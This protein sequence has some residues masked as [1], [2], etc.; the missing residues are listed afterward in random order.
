MRSIVV[1][2][3]CI[4]SV[5]VL[6]IGLAASLPAKAQRLVGS[7][8]AGA[9]GAAEN[10]SFRLTSTVGEP[11]VG[12]VLGTAFRHHAGFLGGFGRS[13]VVT[14]DAEGPVSPE[15]LVLHPPAPN[16]SRGMAH[17]RVD[18]PISA[19]VRLVVYDALGREV[20]VALSEERPA[21]RHVVELGRAG[22]ASGAYV[23]RLVVDGEVR[24]QRLTVVR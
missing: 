9:G 8:L 7:V 23:V 4:R 21:G 18:L 17:V 12:T 13:P 11:V 14:S 24:T 1:S 16:P 10:A 6:L 3:T 15:A 20:A 2:R 19:Y 22:L 5:A